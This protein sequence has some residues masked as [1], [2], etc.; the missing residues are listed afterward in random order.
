MNP[1]STQALAEL[2]NAICDQKNAI[3]NVLAFATCADDVARARRDL[4]LVKSVWHAVGYGYKVAEVLDAVRD[5][6]LALLRAKMALAERRP[7]P[8]PAAVAAE[9]Q[10]LAGMLAELA[11]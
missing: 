11:A 6:A 8:R 1:L 7:G 4:D 10:R 5:A 2:T 3:F 9:L